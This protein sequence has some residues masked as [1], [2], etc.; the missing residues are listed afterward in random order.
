MEN[1]LDEIFALGVIKERIT[2]K[3]DYVLHFDLRLKK[4]FKDLPEDIEIF[5]IRGDDDCGDNA[6]IER[7]VLVNHNAD[8]IFNKKNSKE[9]MEKIEKEKFITIHDDC[10]DYPPADYELY[11]VD[12]TLTYSQFMELTTE[13]LENSKFCFKCNHLIVPDSE[14]YSVCNQNG[15]VS[16]PSCLEDAESKME[17]GDELGGPFCPFCLAALN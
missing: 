7:G 17:D 13:Q 1:F 12:A 15:Q 11:L 9:L 2:G 6:S 16:E 5:S 10:D 4:K 8:L 14:S 3:K